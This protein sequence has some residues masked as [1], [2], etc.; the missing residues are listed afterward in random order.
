MPREE[1]AQEIGDHGMQAMGQ[2]VTI[3][4]LSQFKAP[5]EPVSEHWYMSGGKETE[6]VSY[7]IPGRFEGTSRGKIYRKS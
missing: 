5:I 3:V 4:T 1:L 2:R 7:A 6:K